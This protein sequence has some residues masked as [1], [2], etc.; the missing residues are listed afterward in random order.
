MKVTTL[1]MA[2]YSLVTSY[3]CYHFWEKSQSATDQ[4]LEASSAMSIVVE[5]HDKRMDAFDEMLINPPT[6]ITEV[7]KVVF[8]KVYVTPTSIKVIPIR[9]VPLNPVSDTLKVKHGPVGTFKDLDTIFNPKIERY[10]KC[11][12]GFGVGE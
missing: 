10:S 2:I 1:A 12:T 4:V 7:T 3:G 8:Q 6:E 9:I 5:E 11:G